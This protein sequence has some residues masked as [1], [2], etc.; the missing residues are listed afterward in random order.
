[1]K[2]IDLSAR[3]KFR[4]SGGDRVRYLDGQ[5][6]NAV[7]EASETVAISA[8][9][10]TAK[11]RLQGLVWI[12]VEPGG[13]AFLVDAPAELREPLLARLGK[14]IIADDVELED[15]SDDYVLVHDLG[16]GGEGVASNRFAQPG[17]DR[18]LRKGEILAAADWMTPPA[19]ETLR[20]LQGVPAWGAELTLETLPAEALLDR[21]SVDFHKG[22][23]VGQEVISRVESVGRVNRELVAL[24]F[25]NSEV[26]RGWRLL[27]ADGGVVGDVTSVSAGVGG[28]FFGLGYL[29]RGASAVAVA[30]DAE[31]ILSCAAKTR[32]SPF[33][34]QT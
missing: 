28:G 1:M 31:N 34:T 23:Y 10:T 15:I 11:G 33:T 32:D 6:S 29:R 24:V 25:G 9:V 20:V 8:C 5:V 12:C 3:A 16:D 18:W 17:R 13:D 26:A 2:S 22:C 7:N 21:R 14:Y 4:L 19:V 30:T 27:A